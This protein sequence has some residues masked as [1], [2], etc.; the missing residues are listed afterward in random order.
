MQIKWC[1]GENAIAYCPE[2][3]IVVGSDGFITSA[4][5]PQ[6]LFAAMF[7]THYNHRHKTKKWIPPKT[8]ENKY[9]YLS[10]ITVA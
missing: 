1:I 6:Y 4:S 7:Y 3:L 2:V 9:L 10:P 8:T 5:F